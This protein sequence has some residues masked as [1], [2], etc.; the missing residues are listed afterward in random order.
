M[1]LQNTLRLYEP[2]VCVSGCIRDTPDGGSLCLQTSG[3]AGQ[4]R[5]RREGGG[6][7]KRS[8]EVTA[9]GSPTEFKWKTMRNPR[10]PDGPDE[11]TRK[12]GNGGLDA[13]HSSTR[14]MN[15]CCPAHA[16]THTT[17]T[18]YKQIREGTAGE[19]E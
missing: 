19:D 1:Y 16:H 6:G 12:T 17:A 2:C 15:R 8:Q 13:V 18:R 10:S 14:S 3:V 5:E 4:C 9:G 7:T 11:I